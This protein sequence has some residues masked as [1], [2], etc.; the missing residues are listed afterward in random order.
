MR[1]IILAV[2]SAGSFYALHTETGRV[3]WKRWLPFELQGLPLPLGNA[4]LYLLRHASERDPEAV[5]LLKS[6]IAATPTSHL[7]RV[8]ALRGT[9]THT[10][11][12]PFHPISTAL[13]PNPDTGD[14]NVLVLLSPALDLT[15]YPDTPASRSL[16]AS[17]SAFLYLYSVDSAKG[18]I[19]GYGK[20]GAEA[21]G[22]RWRFSLPAGETFLTLIRSPPEKVRLSLSCVFPPS[23][24]AEFQLICG[25]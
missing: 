4:S 11:T 13:I 23:A 9:V 25:N 7:L 5:V 17:R 6:T 10:M 20:I 24:P 8:N 1:K 19:T 21:V 3:V 14:E 22:M 15:L 12:L 18:T 16:Y 2:S